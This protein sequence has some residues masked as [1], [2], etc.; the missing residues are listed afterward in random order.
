M[1]Q[2]I[3]IA[4]RG[5]IAIRIA[6]TAKQM[7]IRTYMFLTHFEPNALY[8]K[9]ADE[10]IDVSDFTDNNIFLDIEKIVGYATELGIDSIHPGYGFLSENAEL[11]RKC[12]E[13][14]IVFIGPSSNHIEQMGDKGQ[15]RE[16]AIKSNV[17]ILQGS[18]GTVDTI[19][20][21]KELAEKIVFPVIIKAIAGGGGKGMRV[22]LEAGELEKMYN[23]AS[24]EAKSIFN[25]GAVF[26]EK[27]VSRPRHVEVQVIGDKHGNVIHLHERECSIQRKH[28]KLI[29]EAPSPA[30][31]NKTREK[32]GADAVKLCL[33]SGYYSAGTVEFLLDEYN[34]HYFMEMNTRIQVEHP[35][36]EEITGV[37]LIKLQILVANGEQLPLKQE[38]V[39]FEGHAIEFRINAEDVQDNFSPCTGIIEKLEFPVNDQ[40]R[41]DYGYEKNSIV[42]SSFDSLMAKVIISGKDR[43]EAI[44]N[45][46]AFLPHVTIKGIKTTIPFFRKVLETKAFTSGK[47]YTDF[48]ETELDQLYFQEDNEHAV[49]ALLAL[50]AYLDEKDGIEEQQNPQKI[51]RWAIKQI[52]NK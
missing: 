1:I 38:E 6:Q 21:A 5:E 33:D 10:I 7:N 44:N 46:I 52:L 49:A 3:L 32:L 51:S 17:P 35:V 11:A 50:K 30:L 45:A 47:Y 40:I 2:S 41:I 9:E 27:Y 36:T 26:I 22:A 29:E 4:N 13:N 31:D 24:N 28:Q 42:T 25:N 39:K 20:E 37:D 43:D 8:L 48:I 12:E 23:A 15:A 16:M 34:N 14:S 19:E 18:Q